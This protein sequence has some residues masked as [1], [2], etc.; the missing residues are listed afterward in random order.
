VAYNAGVVLQALD[1]REEPAEL[2]L[3]ISLLGK[4][5]RRRRW[6]IGSALSIAAFPLQVVAYSDAP[7]TVVQPGLAVGLVLLLVLGTRYLGESVRRRDYAAIVAILGG[8]ALVAA[9]GP[10]R[11]LPSRGGVGPA[12]VMFILALGM[13]LPYALGKRMPAFAATITISSG[14]AF[15][16]NDLATKLFTDGLDSGGLAIVLGWLAAVAISAVLATLSEMTAFQHAAVRKVVPAVFVLET[17][18]PILLASVMLRGDAGIHANDA[19]P[20]GLG[21]LLCTAAIVVLA[22]SD[23]V[24]WYMHPGQSARR[25]SEARRGRRRQS[26]AAGPRPPRPGSQGPDAN[27]TG[28][29]PRRGEALV[30]PALRRSEERRSWR[31]PG[32]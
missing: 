24:A 25:L 1:A 27:S 30:R 28:P 17:L 22:S 3:R 32:R 14:I 31:G 4:L 8:L 5:L 15:A 7:L 2:G 9:A 10:G 29:S 12:T 18:I 26:Q 23:P 16:W 6:L 19:L 21:L 13:L 11:S 20:I